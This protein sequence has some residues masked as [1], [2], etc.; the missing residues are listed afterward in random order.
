M[1]TIR[2]LLAS[3]WMEYRRHPVLNEAVLWLIALPTFGIAMAERL[4]G[5]SGDPYWT[6]YVAPAGARLPL[7]ALILALNIVIVWG[8]AATLVVARGDKH[9]TFDAIRAQAAPL[10]LP[11]LLTEILRLCL[12]FLWTLALIVPGILYSIRTMLIEPIVAAEGIAYRPA[13]KRSIALVKGRTGQV[14]WLLIGSSLALFVPIGVML[15]MVEAMFSLADP[16]LLAISDALQSAIGGVAS[17]LYVFVLMEA[18]RFLKEHP[19]DK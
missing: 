14:A 12:T 6:D 13:L 19:T 8:M 10:I 4:G 15:G 5:F 3:A 11:I 9:K 16:R 7:I 17:A 2:S 18:Y 1:P